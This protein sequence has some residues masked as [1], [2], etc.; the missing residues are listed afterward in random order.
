MS[1]RKEKLYHV[2]YGMIARCYNTNN[3]KYYLYGGKG[4]KVCKE[5]LEDY[6]VFKEWSY[7]NG[8]SECCGLSIDRMDSDKD[9]CPENCRWI[10]LSENSAKA[11]I[12]RQKN[13]SKNGKMFAENISTGDIVE[14][15]NV[16]KFCREHN[17]D[18]CCVSHRLN[19]IINNPEYNGWKF[20]REK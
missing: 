2:Y 14:I 11:N 1:R 10:S 13:K 16:C 4:I 3:R 15:T 12:G 6:S 9:Y 7:S 17:L 8:Y 18:R 5:W 19:G 20:Y